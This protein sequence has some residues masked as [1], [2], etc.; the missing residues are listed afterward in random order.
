MYDMYPDYSEKGSMF[1]ER[2]DS[3]LGHPDYPLDTSGRQQLSRQTAEAMTIAPEVHAN[4]SVQTQRALGYI[5]GPNS[6]V[7]E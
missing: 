6:M 7:Q 4:L 3:G 1:T 2:G 5:A